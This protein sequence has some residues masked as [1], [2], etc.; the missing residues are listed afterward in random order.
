MVHWAKRLAALQAN[1][2]ESFNMR[3]EFDLM[4]LAALKNKLK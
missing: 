3:M 2:K 1:V 4:V